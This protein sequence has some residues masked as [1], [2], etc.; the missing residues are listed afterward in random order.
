MHRRTLVLGALAWA[1][2]GWSMAAAAGIR[3]FD[4]SAFIT[5]Q[6]AGK[7]II[8]FVHAPW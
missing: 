6:D 3:P 7:S 4:R 8:V 5:A 2:T 1:V